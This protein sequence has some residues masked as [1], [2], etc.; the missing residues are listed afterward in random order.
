MTETRCRTSTPH[1]LAASLVCVLTIAGTV[2]VFAE[3]CEAHGAAT[4]YAVTVLLGAGWALSIL[5]TIH[6]LR[7]RKED[8]S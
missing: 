5:T 6:E 4:V 7:E 2:A 1:Y 8:R 3:L